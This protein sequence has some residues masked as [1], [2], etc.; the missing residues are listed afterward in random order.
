MEVRSYTGGEKKL[1][2]PDSNWRS[3]DGKFKLG[4]E[5]FGKGVCGS[6]IPQSEDHVKISWGHSFESNVQSPIC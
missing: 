5:R 1:C 3:G 4:M 6:L 2:F